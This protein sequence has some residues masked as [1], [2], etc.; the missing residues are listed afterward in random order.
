MSNGSMQDRFKSIT[1]LPV[2]DLLFRTPVEKTM[3]VWEGG[4]AT[5]SYM[6]L[7]ESHITARAM[8]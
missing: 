7:H 3:G 8:C 1:A 2:G 6:S 4:G 5:N